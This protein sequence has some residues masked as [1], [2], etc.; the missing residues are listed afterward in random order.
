MPKYLRL[1]QAKNLF[2]TFYY[3]DFES[4]KER[5]EGYNTTNTKAIAGLKYTF[6][7]KKLLEN[8]DRCYKDTFYTP[9]ETT[10]R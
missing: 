1:L 10:L 7:T 2:P 3:C 6:L 4:E 9:I 5:F 8:K